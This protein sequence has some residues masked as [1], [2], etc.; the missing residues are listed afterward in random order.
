VNPEIS[1]NRCKQAST[2]GITI[3][4]ALKRSGFSSNTDGPLLASV[5]YNPHTQ[6]SE[7]NGVPFLDAGAVA[8]ATT[9]HTT[10]SIN[11]EDTD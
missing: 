2:E 10:T 7:I 4:F 6:M 11:S 1:S 8:I 5:S 3:M 9:A